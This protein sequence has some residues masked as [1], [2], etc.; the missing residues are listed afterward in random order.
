MGLWLLLCLGLLESFLE[1]WLEGCFWLGLGFKYR[2]KCW[3]RLL[4]LKHGLGYWLG[5]WFLVGFG[6][7]LECCFRLWSR[8][9]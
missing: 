2:C 6:F 3:L 4:C 1:L 7:R 5:L 9:I 8:F